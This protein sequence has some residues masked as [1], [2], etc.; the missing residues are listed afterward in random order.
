MEIGSSNLTLGQII[1]FN[2]KVMFIFDGSGNKGK[3][4]NFTVRV[5]VI[6]GV[7]NC[8]KVGGKSDDVLSSH[9]N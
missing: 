9:N 5:I 8:N 1:P 3:D 4:G 7:C 2:S 6:N